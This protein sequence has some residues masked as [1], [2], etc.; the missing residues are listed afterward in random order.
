[1]REA[2]RKVK[3]EA[4]KLRKQLQEEHEKLKEQEQALLQEIRARL[5]REGDE[6]QREIRD[7]MY[8]L[9]KERSQEKLE[10]ARNAMAAMREKLKS[11]SWQPPAPS[12]VEAVPAIAVGDKVWLVG[13]NV[14]GTV[15][16][17][18]D[19]N[20]QVDV[21]VGS[22]RIKMSPENLEKGKA[23]TRQAVYTSP[24]RNLPRR[25]VSR[26]LDLRGRRA[27]E[28]EVELDS[29]LNEVA[30]ANLPEVRIIHGIATG[31]VR[32]IVRQFLASHPL[33]ES[34]RSGNK[35]EGGD[36]VTIVKL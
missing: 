22:T 2:V 13:M 24:G 21:Q 9:K 3:E 11:Q 8:D 36:G 34:F 14:Q 7:A 23:P 15:V 30:M 31:T 6:L 5:V 32:Q 1:M 20:G 27:D 12:G 18:P 25:P 10:R 33:V 17:P 26:E 4:E 35:E 28:V 29:Y 16:S 19:S